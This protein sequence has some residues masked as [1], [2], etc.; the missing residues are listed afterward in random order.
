MNEESS[1]Q[2]DRKSKKQVSSQLA[3]YPG[4]FF[5]IFADKK[6]GLSKKLIAASFFAYEDKGMAV[7]VL[8]QEVS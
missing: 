6:N 3:S 2:T 8:I 5:Y 1:T 4:Q 7:R